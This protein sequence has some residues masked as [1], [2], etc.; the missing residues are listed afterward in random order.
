MP[1]VPPENG[2]R[3]RKTD[4]AMLTALFSPAVQKAELLPFDAN[5]FD[6]TRS[7]LQRD[8]LLPSSDS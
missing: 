4:W 3:N 2:T 7:V 5:G 6:C 1:G 8:R